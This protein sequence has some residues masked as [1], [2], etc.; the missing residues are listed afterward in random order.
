VGLNKRVQAAHDPFN[1]MVKRI[2]KNH[3]EWFWNE[4]CATNETSPKTTNL[5]HSVING[6]TQFTTA[7]GKAN[8]SIPARTPSKVTCK[9]KPRFMP[10]TASNTV[11][12]VMMVDTISGLYP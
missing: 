7:N 8:N 4:Y 1:G 9:P 12:I 2:C 3:G 6:I 10:N 11:E 5:D